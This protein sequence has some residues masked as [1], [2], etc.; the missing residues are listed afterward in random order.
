[1]AFDASR[2]AAG[3]VVLAAALALGTPALA[4]EGQAAG[5]QTLPEGYRNVHELVADLPDFVPG[6][7]ALYVHPEGLPVGPYLGFSREGE[8]MNTTYMIPLDRL[9]QEETLTALTPTESPVD[10]VELKYNPGHPGMAVPHYHVILWH[11]GPQQA[12]ELAD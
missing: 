5:V 4:A 6:L 7:G 9:N 2:T 1:M 12:A 10:H 8:L 3:A 11:V